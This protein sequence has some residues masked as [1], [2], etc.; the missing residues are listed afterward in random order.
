MTDVMYYNNLI[1]IREIFIVRYNMITQFFKIL[2][3]NFSTL[4]KNF[5]F[6]FHLISAISFI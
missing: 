6:N 4:K 3:L 1:A 5:V 2:E